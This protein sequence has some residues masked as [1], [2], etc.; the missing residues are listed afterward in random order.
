[1]YLL[2]LIRIKL[3][4]ADTSS[5][6]IYYERNTQKSTPIALDSGSI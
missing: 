3:I 6:N 5:F 1:M 4:A 2:H